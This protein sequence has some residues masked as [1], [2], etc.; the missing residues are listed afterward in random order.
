MLEWLYVMPFKHFEDFCA[1]DVFAVAQEVAEVGYGCFQG[2]KACG[3]LGE[4][5]RPSVVVAVVPGL[6]EIEHFGMFS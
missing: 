3:G 2:V 6:R 4:G 1:V 5:I